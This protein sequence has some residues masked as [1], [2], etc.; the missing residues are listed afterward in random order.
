MLKPRTLSP[1]PRLALARRAAG[2]QAG[3]RADVRGERSDAGNERPQVEAD[4][5]DRRQQQNG[6]GA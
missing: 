1:A 2:I 5:G 6:R 4:Q 3:L